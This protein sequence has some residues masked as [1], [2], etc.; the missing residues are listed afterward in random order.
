MSTGKYLLMILGF[1]LMAS[2]K[3]DKNEPVVVKDFTIEALTYKSWKPVQIDG[4][5]SINPPSGTYQYYAVQ[6]WDKDDLITYKTDSK[7]YYSYGSMMAP[8]SVEM[9]ESKVYSVD[10]PKKTITISGITYQLLEVSATRL[11]YS[12]TLGGGNPTLVFMFE[13]P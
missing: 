1:F 11:K 7:V 5:T 12:L 2:C 4:N 9:P 6:I 3:K 8:I 13:H 10:L